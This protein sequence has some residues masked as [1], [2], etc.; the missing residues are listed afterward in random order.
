VTLDDLPFTGPGGTPYE[1]LEPLWV[2]HIEVLRGANG[3]TRGALSLGG[4]INYA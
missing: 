4:L 2:D 3:L 1:L